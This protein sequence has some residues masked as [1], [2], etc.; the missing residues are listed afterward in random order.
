[1]IRAFNADKPYNRFLLEQ[2]AG[3]ELVDYE[4]APALTQDMVDNLVAT[5]FLR[6]TED[7]TSQEEMGSLRLI[8]RTV[9]PV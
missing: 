4:H 9:V 5:G 8:L 6:M 7:P 2:I 3:D 1:M